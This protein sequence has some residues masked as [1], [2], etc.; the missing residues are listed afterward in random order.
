[1]TRVARL[2]LALIVGLALLTWAASSMVQ[3]TAFGWFERDARSRAELVLIGARPALADAWNDSASLNRQLVTP[4]S[5]QRVVGTAAR[6]RDQERVAW[7][8]AG[9]SSIGAAI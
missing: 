5:D 6:L 9:R 3:T 2:I 7:R 1:M 4:A 8:L